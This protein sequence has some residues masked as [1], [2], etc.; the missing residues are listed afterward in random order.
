MASAEV[1]QHHLRVTASDCT[2]GNHV[3]YSRYLDWLE[4]A[5]WA[6]R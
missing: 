3:Y 6:S 1:F 5:R 4:A 2:V